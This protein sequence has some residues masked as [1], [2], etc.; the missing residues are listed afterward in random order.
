MPKTTGRSDLNALPAIPDSPA[1]PSSTDSTASSPGPDAAPRE[2][3]ASPL[4]P[5]PPVLELTQP[6]AFVSVPVVAIFDETHD[7]RTFRMSRPLGFDFHAGQFLTVAMKID[8]DWMTQRF[9]ISSAPESFGYLE[10]SVKRQG[11]VSEVLHSAVSVGSL[12]AVHPPAGRFAYPEGDPRHLVLLAGGAGSTALMSMLRHAVVSHPSRPVTLLLS[13]RTAMD[14]PFRRELHMLA[15]Q[16]PQVRVGVTLTRES[17]RPG[18]FAGRIDETLLR[19]SVPDLASALYYV[20]GP[21]P[22]VDGMKRLLS[23][24]GVPADQVRTEVLEVAPAAA[25]PA[26]AAAP[27]A[28]PELPAPLAIDVETRLE[29]PSGGVSTSA[30]AEVR[31]ADSDAGESKSSPPPQVLIFPRKEQ[32]R[33]VLRF[34]RGE[35]MLHWS[36]AIPFILCFVTGVT[37]KLLFNLHSESLFR[38]VLSFLHRVA[39]GCLAVFPTLAVLRN[40]RDYKVHIYNVKVGFSWTIDDLKWLFLVGPATV[41]KRIVLPEQRKFNAAERMNFMMVMVT[42]PLFVATGVFLWGHGVDHFIPWVV[43]VS[44]SLVAPLLMFG[45]IYMAVVNP[46]TR[47]GLSGMI[48]GRV[49]REWAKHHYRRWYQEHFEEDGTP[50]K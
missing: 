49:D 5:P 43:H 41:S 40:W 26:I 22:M 18:Y 12:L 16:D 27:G 11:H 19:K 4:D 8:G 32:V 20:C 44:L 13:V 36:I 21:T 24:L 14:I 30:E 9:P 3:A 33:Q 17:R 35:M 15:R 10:I 7:I 1:D 50:K 48:T 37:M 34:A 6:T 25:R 2:L 47:V 29:G 31:T 38:D 39:G 46:S 23:G 45:H 42:Y 28:P